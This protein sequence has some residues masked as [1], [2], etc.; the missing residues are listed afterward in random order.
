MFSRKITALAIAAML[1]SGAIGVTA[2][3]A[4]VAPTSTAEAHQLRTDAMKQMGGLLRSAPNATGA[5]A[6]AAAT[7]LLNTFTNLPQM[8]PEGSSE[9]TDALPAIWENWETFTGIIETGRSAAETALAAAEAGDTDTYGT[10]L[11]TVMGTCGQCH[12]QFRS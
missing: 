3:D 1:A 2:Q 9:G 7:T 6:V 5:D 11:R 8:F 10:A 4:F 12:Q